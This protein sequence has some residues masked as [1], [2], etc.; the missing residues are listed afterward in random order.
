LAVAVGVAAYKLVPKLT[1]PVATLTVYAIGTVAAY[2]MI[3]RVVGY[4]V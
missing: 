4:V 1:R 2:W 3:E